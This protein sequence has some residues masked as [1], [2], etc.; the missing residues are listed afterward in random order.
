[1]SKFSILTTILLTMICVNA[2]VAVEA[3]GYGPSKTIA[4]NEALRAAVEQGAGVKIFSETEVRDFVA[5][6]DV[7]ISESFGLVTSYQVLEKKRQGRDWV[8]RIRAMVS[9]SVKTQWDQMK[10]ILKQKGSPTIMFC[11][12][13]T[14]DGQLRPM[15]TGEYKLVQKFKN[16]GFTVIDRQLAE[17]TKKLH[18][19]LYSLDQNHQGIIAVAAK[20]NA[21][22]VVIGTLAGSFVRYLDF[23]G[24]R[25]MVHNYQFSTKII[26]TDTSQIVGSMTK[27]YQKRYDTMQYNRDTAGKAG[28]ASVIDIKYIQPMMVDLLKTWIRDVQQG[29]DIVIVVSNVKFRMRKKILRTFESMTDYISEVKVGHYRNKRLELRLK[30]KLNNEQLAEKLE[31]IPGL[32][33]EVVDFQKNRLELRYSPSEY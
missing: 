15:S 31:E 4:T 23:Y 14:L 21:D 3:T 24:S 18:T 29:T 28:F 30:S 13:E 5:L 20:R 8:V 10:I 27:N 33:L 7:M 19:Q 17:E 16:L 11:I 12:K 6:K 26:R 2:D 1:M 9:A 25:R 32:P 22:L